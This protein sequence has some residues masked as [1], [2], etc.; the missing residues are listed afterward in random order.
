MTVELEQAF[1]NIEIICANAMLNRE[2][3]LQLTKDIRLIFDTCEAKL[4]K[5]DKKN[6][7]D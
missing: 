2:Q 5:K 1:K 7:S 3:H 4:K 6:A